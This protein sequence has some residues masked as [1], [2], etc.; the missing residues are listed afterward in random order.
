MMYHS[1]HPLPSPLV[2]WG[3]NWLDVP[4]F[5]KP[6]P[7]WFAYPPN[8]NP[9]RRRPYPRLGQTVAS[10]STSRPLHSHSSR[11]RAYSH[12]HPH[13]LRAQFAPA[14]PISLPI[15]GL[16]RES[17][18]CLFWPPLTR[19]L[20]ICRLPLGSRIADVNGCA[21][22]TRPGVSPCGVQRTII[23]TQAASISATCIS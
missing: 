15:P 5:A 23:G 11:T 4:A 3:P 2:Q 21:T 6:D 8:P 16:E 13:P 22:H 9:P 7:S 18:L 10:P 14:L 17:L 12:S 20:S 19:L 1:S